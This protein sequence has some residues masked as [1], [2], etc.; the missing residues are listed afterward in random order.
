M[1]VVAGENPLAVERDGAWQGRGP[2]DSLSR[3]FGFFFF[4]K[5]QGI[6]VST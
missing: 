1:F 3:R 2:P 4:F 5:L 6:S